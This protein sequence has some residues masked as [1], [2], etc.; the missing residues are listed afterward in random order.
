MIVVPTELVMTGAPVAA[1]HRLQGQRSAPSRQ[2]QTRYDEERLSAMTPSRMHE[3]LRKSITKRPPSELTDLYYR[4]DRRVSMASHLS[5]MPSAHVNQ[6]FV[7]GSSDDDDDRD[8][9]S[10]TS[11]DDSD[12]A[13][14][15]AADIIRATYTSP[16]F[17][18]SNA[19]MTTN[20]ESA[21]N[22]VD[23]C[24]VDGCPLNPKSRVSDCI[25]KRKNEVHCWCNP[26]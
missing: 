21:D 22:S 6:S 25:K 19:T 4:E 3:P 24:P 8:A 7:R 15:P 1:A 18:V 11:S 20:V 2:S 14:S 12:L 26:L 13:R 16:M 9:G 10:V 17:D 23:P 5:A